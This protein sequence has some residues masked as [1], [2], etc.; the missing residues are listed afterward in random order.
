MQRTLPCGVPRRSPALS[1]SRPKL[2]TVGVEMLLEG[3][4]LFL[5]RRT[6]FENPVSFPGQRHERWG[7][8]ERAIERAINTPS[9]ELVAHVENP[10]CLSVF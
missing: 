10:T 3:G 2:V 8:G 6:G 5:V 1:E 9:I 4:P 7:L